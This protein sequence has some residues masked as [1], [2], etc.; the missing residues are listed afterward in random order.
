MSLVA[1]LTLAS[2]CSSSRGEREPNTD[3][4]AKMD[5]TVA[6]AEKEEK[7]SEQPASAQESAKDTDTITSTK[8]TEY[9]YPIRDKK[10]HI[11]KLE[12][13]YGV[14]ILELYRD[15]APNHADSFLARTEEGFYDSTI[16]HR[17]MKGFMIQGGDPTGTGMGDPKRP[18]YFLNQEFSKQPHLRGTLSMARRSRGGAGDPDGHN[19]ASAQF[20]ICHA[21]TPSL[22]GQYTVFGH[23]LKGYD[24]LDK[25][26]ST[27]TGQANRPVNDIRIIKASKVS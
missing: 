3:T 18:G 14:M 21:V 7:M 20:F 22:D 1:L 5:A 17:V 24:V 12:T 13:N 4:P 25:I 16:F 23:L 26:A 19:T 8:A 9:E 15:V 11:V 27:K 10:N 2:G 6:Q